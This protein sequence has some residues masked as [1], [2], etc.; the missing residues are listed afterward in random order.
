MSHIEHSGNVDGKWRVFRRLDIPKLTVSRSIV[1]SCWT[2]YLDL[3]GSF[4]K[5]HHIPFVRAG[6]PSIIIQP[7]WILITF[8]TIP[9]SEF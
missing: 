8:K 6:F 3:A 7:K 9:A 1:F 4:L 5:S 2:R